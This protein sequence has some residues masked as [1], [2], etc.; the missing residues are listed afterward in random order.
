[1][2]LA[3]S[4]RSSARRSAEVDDA[5]AFRDD[6]YDHVTTQMTATEV[7]ATLLSVLDAVADGDEVEITR[8]GRTV[9]KL[10]PASGPPALAGTLTGIAAT[11]ADD[12]LFTTG[13]EWDLR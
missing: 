2:S 5:C 1:V 9:A 13:A 8:H 6:Q 3:R 12:D 7:K 4:A 11:A 10:I